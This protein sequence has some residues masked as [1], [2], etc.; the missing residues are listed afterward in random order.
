MLLSRRDWVA[1][2]DTIFTGGS[3][4]TPFSYLIDPRPQVVLRAIS[5]DPSDT[6]FTVNFGTLR[7]VWFFHFQ[8]FGITSLATIRL[9]AGIDPTFATNVFDTGEISGWPQDKTPFST[10]PWGELTLNGQY[11]PE[12][13]VALGM[14]RFIVPTS[15]ISVQYVKVEIFDPTAN[16][17]AQ[18]GTFGAC[19]AWEPQYSDFGWT[20]VF[21]DET[22]IQTIPYGSRFFIPFGRRR[23]INIGL[24][25]KS[26]QL[27]ERALGWAAIMGKSTPT[28]IMPFPDDIPNIEK[29]AVYGTIADDVTIANPSWAFYQMPISV[30]Q[31]I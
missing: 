25:F 31:L 30:E 14:P 9:R 18:I 28:V 3:W 24:S 2:P 5:P 22:D 10:T 6:T 8:S 23:R 29:R 12:E 19:E 1:H 20:T 16:V 13:Y 7:K 4:L 26:Q 21:I 11:E 15:E 27:L 17:P